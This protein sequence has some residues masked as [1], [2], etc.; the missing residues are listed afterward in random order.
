M[1][2]IGQPVLEG[3]AIVDNTTGE[4]W[5][6]VRMSLVSGKPISFISQLYQPRYVQRKTADLPELKALA[7]VIHG[8]AYGG[9]SR[10]DL[11]DC[12]VAVVSGAERSVLQ[13]KPWPQLL[14]R[15]CS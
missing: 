7:P 8:G 12:G 1:D 3:W 11:A 4:D 2:A 6:N 14:P 13:A 5:I 10:P 9:G 15:D